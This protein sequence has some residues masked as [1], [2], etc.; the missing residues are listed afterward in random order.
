[1]GIDIFILS[2]AGLSLI[3]TINSPAEVIYVSNDE[4]TQIERDAAALELYL[5]DKEDHKK[6]CPK[7]KWDQPSIDKYKEDLESQ[8]PAGCKK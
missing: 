2:F 8:L 5:Q 4:L 1:M 7:T 3:A 6:Y